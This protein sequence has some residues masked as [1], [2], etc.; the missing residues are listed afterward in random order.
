MVKKA[1]SVET[2]PY[3]VSND[4]ILFSNMKPSISISEET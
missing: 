3:P 1:Y 2:N 4:S